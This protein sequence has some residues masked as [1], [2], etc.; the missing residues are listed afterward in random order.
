MRRLPVWL[1]RALVPIPAALLRAGHALQRFLTLRVGW[2]LFRPRADDIYIATYPRSGTT[3]MQMMLHQ[4][5]S[6]GGMDFSHINAVCPWIELEIFRNNAAGLEALPS[7]RVFKTHLLYREL[8]RT[9]LYIYVLRDVRDVAVSAFHNSRLLGKRIS[10]EAFTEDFLR[11]G[12]GASSTWFEHLRS[13]WPHRHKPNVL[14]LSYEEIV[15]DLPGTIRKVARFCGL[16]APETEL[17]R[18]LERCSLSFM[19]QH[20][21]KLDS[22]FQEVRPSLEG[23]IRRGESTEGTELSPRHRERLDRELSELATELGCA[24][25]VPYRELLDP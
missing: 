22:R 17:P 9:G 13:W 2:S 18:I 20:E 7:P 14:F 21:E 12:W 11:T 4:L 23:F 1:W 3:L 19:K 5:K 25:G 15:A 10:L 6:D 8:P 24:R 16:D